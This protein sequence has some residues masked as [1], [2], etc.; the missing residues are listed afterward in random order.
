[1]LQQ[2]FDFLGKQVW[3][4]A[5]LMLVALL[6]VLIA[7]ISY[8]LTFTMSMCEVKDSTYILHDTTYRLNTIVQKQGGAVVRL[9]VKEVTK[10]RQSNLVETPLKAG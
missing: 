5:V 1:M 6:V 4:L 8:P 2:L 3:V 7:T 10:T 9:C